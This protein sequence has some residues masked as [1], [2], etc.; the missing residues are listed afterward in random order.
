[1]SSTAHC[2][3]SGGRWIRGPAQIPVFKISSEALCTVAWLCVCV[4]VRARACACA[5]A[6][7]PACVVTCV[8]NFIV[9]AIHIY[10]MYPPKI[11]SFCNTLLLVSAGSS[12][13]RTPSHRL[14]TNGHVAVLVGGSEEG[15]GEVSPPEKYAARHSRGPAVMLGSREGVINEFWRPSSR[16]GA[17]DA[18]GMQVSPPRGG[19]GGG[20]VNGGGEARSDDV[21]RGNFLF[22][23]PGGGGWGMRGGRC[24]NW[25]PAPSTKRRSSRGSSVSEV[26]MK[27]PGEEEE[28][29]HGFRVSGVGRISTQFM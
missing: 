13:S 3:R 19:G 1:M 23:G 14:P 11:S 17:D 8:R 21:K 10:L 18:L 9:H 7:L 2:T 26:R 28:Y 4:C 25:F 16:L 12:H 6:C 15:V 22:V 29:A 5:Q 24:V 27:G 20:E